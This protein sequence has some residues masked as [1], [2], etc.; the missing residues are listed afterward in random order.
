MIPGPRART[1][2]HIRLAQLDG[3]HRCRTGDRRHR[4]RAVPLRVDGGRVLD[5]RPRRRPLD[6]PVPRRSRPHRQPAGCAR[7]LPEGD[8]RHQLVHRRT[9]RACNGAPARSHAVDQLRRVLRRRRSDVHR[10]ATPIFDS[11]TTRGSARL[12]DRRLLGSGHLRVAPSRPRHRTDDVPYELWA[13]SF[14]FFAQMVSP[15]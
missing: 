2:R 9:D 3:H 10:R 4:Q 8:A 5:R 7:R 6:L 12:E 1:S 11:P 13:E 14:T 15:W